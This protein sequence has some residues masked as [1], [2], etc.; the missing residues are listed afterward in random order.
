MLLLSTAYFEMTSI[1]SLLPQSL[2]PNSK[3]CSKWKECTRRLIE[4]TSR[5]AFNLKDKCSV[6]FFNDLKRGAKEET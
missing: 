2:M 3:H 1:S 4:Q 5:C 6:A